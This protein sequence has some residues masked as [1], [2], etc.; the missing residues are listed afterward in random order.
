V[1]SEELRLKASV[2]LQVL[3][4]GEIEKLHSGM[5]RIL[6]NTGVAIENAALREQLR[7]YG[8]VVDEGRQ[9]VR[10][11]AAVVEQFLR[12]IER[13]DY[14]NVQPRVSAEVGVYQGMYLVPGSNEFVHF[15]A[16]AVA[17]YV[18]LARLLAGVSGVHVL[19]YPP[20]AGRITEPLECRI[21]AWK[22]GA[23]DAGSIQATQLCPYILEMYKVRAS[24]EGK[25]LNEVF[26]G[27]VFM[28]SPLRLPASEAD[29]LMFF[30]DHGL[31]VYISNMLTLGGSAPITL[32]GALALN[33]AEQ[34][35]I[36][37]INLVLYGDRHWA[38]GCM[39]APID[40]RT[41]MQPYGRP[42]M[43]LANLANMQIAQHYGV[44]AGVHSGLTDAK[45]PSAEAGMQKLLTAL[46]CALAGGANIEP[47]LLSIDEVFSPIQMILDAELA[48]AVQHV[49]R[50]YV[51]DEETM[52]IDLIDSVGPGGLF[53]EQEHT[54]KHYR[55]EQW[56]PR[57]WSREMLQS[58]LRSGCKTDVDRALEVWHEMMAKPDFEPA[59]SQELERGLR[60]VVRS[61]EARLM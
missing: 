61:A 49:L 33:L 52:A 60:E 9:R 3:S 1:T 58:W 53:T 47:G 56:Q 10:F 20:A 8:G 48:S 32:A 43:L 13:V 34:V 28:V 35:V 19:N 38:I 36:G 17:K 40:M 46:P 54:A 44:P 55:H 29:Q 16:D 11:P 22:H 14:D 37:I 27:G 7:S 4:Q 31:R 42:E 6:E 59:V 39:I 50:D 30:F 18:K 15:D 5:L 26:R 2:A 45:V 57:I 41:A 12:T 24:A 23:E 25:S 51:I 21:F